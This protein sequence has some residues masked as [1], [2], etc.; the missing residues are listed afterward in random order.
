ISRIKKGSDENEKSTG[1]GLVNF[2]ITCCGNADEILDKSKEILLTIDENSIDEHPDNNW[3]ALL[4]DWFI[5]RCAPEMTKEEAEKWKEKWMKMS[6]KKRAKMEEKRDWSLLNWLY[7]FEHDNRTWFWWDA[8]ITNNNT[9][10][11]SVETFGSPFPWGALRWLF[12]A[13]GAAKVVQVG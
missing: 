11:L 1:I 4:P 3:E 7:W 12:I 13:C 10:I 5:D 2:V 8:S 6:P 9:I